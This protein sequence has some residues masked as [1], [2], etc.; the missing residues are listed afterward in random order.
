[1]LIIPGLNVTLPWQLQRLRHQLILR[2]ALPFS[3]EHLEPDLIL[4]RHL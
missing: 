4:Q 3:P 2:M 1:M